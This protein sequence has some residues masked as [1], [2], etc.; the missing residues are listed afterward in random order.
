VD[1]P[2]ILAFKEPTELVVLFVVVSLGFPQPEK[3][4]IVE[5][6]IKVRS[7]KVSN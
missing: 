7:I 2:A 1:C 4:K 6:A 3:A 5:M